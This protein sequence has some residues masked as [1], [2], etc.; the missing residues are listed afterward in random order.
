ML[1]TLQLVEVHMKPYLLET[2]KR[3]LTVVCGGALAPCPYQQLVCEATHAARSTICKKIVRFAF[4]F[5]C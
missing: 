5:N 2:T 4:K 3:P 1:K